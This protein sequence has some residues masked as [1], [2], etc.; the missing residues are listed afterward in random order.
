MTYLMMSACGAGTIAAI[1]DVVTWVRDYGLGCEDG[2]RI[3]SDQRV[4][5]LIMGY[6]AFA[7]IVVIAALQYVYRV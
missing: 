7:C 1:D 4:A 3:C 2:F 5:Y 6:L